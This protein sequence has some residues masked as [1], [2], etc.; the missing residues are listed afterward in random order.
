MAGRNLFVFHSANYV[1]IWNIYVLASHEIFARFKVFMLSQMSY[2][3]TISVHTCHTVSLQLQSRTVDINAS[4]YH[5]V[6]HILW[7]AILLPVAITVRIL[8]WFISLV[9]GFFSPI[10]AHFGVNIFGWCQHSF[11]LL[12]S[13]LA[14]IFLFS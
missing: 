11:T 6:P 13:L 7:S 2:P 1:T 9:D 4:H 14:S 8:W 3:W 12:H 5:M 10:Y